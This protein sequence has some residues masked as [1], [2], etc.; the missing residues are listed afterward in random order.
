MNAVFYKLLKQVKNK[1]ILHNLTQE[2]R[3]WIIANF[4]F[5]YSK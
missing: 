3:T 1:R 4:A 2:A 5:Y